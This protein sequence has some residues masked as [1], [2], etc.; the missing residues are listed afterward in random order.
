MLRNT[1][2]ILEAPDFSQ[3]YSKAVPPNLWGQGSGGN[4]TLKGGCDRL[5]LVT[6]F[7]YHQ[8]ED[9]K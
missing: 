9:T 5:A 3:V 8:H 7:K 1:R 2:T 4:F 6:F